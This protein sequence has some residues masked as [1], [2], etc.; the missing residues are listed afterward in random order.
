MTVPICVSKTLR[1][2]AVILICFGVTLFTDVSSFVR[3]ETF[4]LSLSV[5]FFLPYS[6]RFQ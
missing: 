5:S 4:P 1:L 3:G 6:L 2:F